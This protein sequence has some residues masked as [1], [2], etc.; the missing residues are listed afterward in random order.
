M[1]LSEPVVSAPETVAVEP[2][3]AG[4]MVMSYLLMRLFVGVIG[5]LLPPLLIV[6]NWAI[7]YGFQPSLSGYYYT[8]M[9]NFFVGAL[10]ALA[11]FLV[12]YNG[13]DL[14]DRMITNIAGVATIATALLPT[15]PPTDPDLRQ[16]VIG[17]LHLTVA[18]VAFV[19]LAVMALRFAKREPTPPGLP[20]WRRV[21]YAFGFT[22]AADSGTPRWEVVVYRV[23]GF[24]ML[25]CL[26]LLYPLSTVA[27][28]SLLTLETTM[29]VF[30]GLSWFVKGRKLLT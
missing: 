29:L 8:P 26:L 1:W 20:F 4:E 28:Y 21:G 15:T 11:I 18:C 25:G 23:S 19:L 10:C 16:V 17:D 3:P 2:P 12:A 22:G 6:G 9:R 24:V 27:T 7:G 30:F 14:A 5:M 13:Y